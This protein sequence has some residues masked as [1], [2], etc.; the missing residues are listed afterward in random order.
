MQNKGADATK[1]SFPEPRIRFRLTHQV[2]QSII[3]G[4]TNMSQKDKREEIAEDVHN[5]HLQNEI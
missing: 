5:E 2:A 4:N 3:R 1:F